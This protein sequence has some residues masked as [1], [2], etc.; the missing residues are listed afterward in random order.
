MLKTVLVTVL[1]HPKLDDASPNEQATKVE[2]SHSSGGQIKTDFSKTHDTSDEQ[3][4][5]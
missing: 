1:V 4:N 3:P 5:L 2:N